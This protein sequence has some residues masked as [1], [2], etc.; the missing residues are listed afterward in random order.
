MTTIGFTFTLSDFQL[1]RFD[2]PLMDVASDAAHVFFIGPACKLNL[3]EKVGTKTWSEGFKR[4]TLKKQRGRCTWCNKP[5]DFQDIEVDHVWPIAKGGRHWVF[6]LQVLH[7]WCN[8]EKA[9]SINFAL[10]NVS[11]LLPHLAASVR[12]LLKR[13][14]ILAAIVGGIALVVAGILAVKWLREYVDGVRRYALLAS[15]VRSNVNGLAQQVRGV[16][17]QVGREAAHRVE[18][19]ARELPTRSGFVVTRVN[20][21]SSVNLPDTA[22]NLPDTAGQAVRTALRASG[23][24]GESART[25][26]SRVKRGASHAPNLAQGAA[27]RAARILPRPWLKTRPSFAPKMYGALSRHPNP[28]ATRSST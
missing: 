13:P 9:A 2:I 7:W 26:A 22:V 19:A 5:L 10:N 28:L 3:I 25:A 23:L 6:N 14:W 20:D 12:W 8:R 17:V 15:R 27:A 21:A 1:T 16:A 11:P 18:T 4:K 24:V